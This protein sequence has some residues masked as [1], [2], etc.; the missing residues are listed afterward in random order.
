MTPVTM[1]VGDGHDQGVRLD[2]TCRD[3]ILVWQ[4]RRQVRG[5]PLR[6]GQGEP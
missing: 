5:T 4:A 6:G 2:V 1:S 3:G